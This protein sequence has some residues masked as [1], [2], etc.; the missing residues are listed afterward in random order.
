MTAA[1]F[2]RIVDQKRVSS[3]LVKTDKG[4]ERARGAEARVSKAIA[5]FPEARARSQDELKKE[6]G[7]QVNQLLGL[8]YALLAMS[9]IISAFGIVNTLTLSIFER[10]RELGL[11]RAVG[12]TRRDVRRM[13]RYESVIT[14]V[15][16]ALLGLVLGL[17]FAFVVIQAL[18]GEGIAFSLPIGQIVSL[19]IFAIVVGVVAAIF[20]ARRA[21]RLDVL[22][23]IAYE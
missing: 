21:S 1:P 4:D 19:L 5:A 3:V 16:G 23:A 17:F 15:F 20:P 22:R 2:D 11:L 14:A 7:D 8:F 10:T 6:N 13:V 12:M 9:V 18:E